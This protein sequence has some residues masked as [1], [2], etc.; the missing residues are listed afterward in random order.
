[1][2]IRKILFLCEAVNIL[3]GF[4]CY[5]IVLF[6]G[7]E[8]TCFCFVDVC[9]RKFEVRWSSY[10]NNNLFLK[11]VGLNAVLFLS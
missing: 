6:K 8:S 1:M 10:V 3:T 7:S 2:H 11:T 5:F 9:A 4:S